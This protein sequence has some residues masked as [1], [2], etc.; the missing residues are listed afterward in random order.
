M[1]LHLIKA[2]NMRKAMQKMQATLGS[3]AMIYRTRHGEYGVEVLAGVG[4]DHGDASIVD[5]SEADMN[6]FSGKPV[7][8]SVEDKISELGAHIQA[9]NEKIRL[10]VRSGDN[11]NIIG[12]LKQACYQTL[13]QYGFSK[14]AYEA[15]FADKFKRARSIVN[16]SEFIWKTL[17][18]NIAITKHELVDQAGFCAIVGPT[19]VGKS[20][21]IVKL[22]TRYVKRYGSEGLGIITTDPADMTIKN[23]LTHYCDQLKVDLEYAHSTLDL[24]HSIQNMA[25]KK[26]VLIDTYGISQKDHYAIN[27]LIL[28]LESCKK[29]VS[30]YLALPCEH[31]EEVL[32]DIIT[33]F[34]F[35]YTSGCILTKMDEASNVNPAMTLAIRHHLPIA[36]ICDGQDVERDIR[37]PN[38][39]MLISKMMMTT[40]PIFERESLNPEVQCHFEPTWVLARGMTP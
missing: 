30:V 9:L 4:D 23:M 10:L 34:H 19:G 8:R 6:A 16:M 7:H 27:A 38:K 1:K 39:S 3:H 25:N 32:E 29:K 14:A 37:Y 40:D 5:Y 2:E 36:Y 31:Q 28:L 18:K 33:Q 24:N 22:A 13:T 20:T 35:K 12:D 15:I 26:L 11:G 21:T 17:E